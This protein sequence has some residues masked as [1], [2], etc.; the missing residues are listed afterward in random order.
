VAE[1]NLDM[2]SPDT[3]LL[4]LLMGLRVFDKYV[5]EN[6]R[7]PASL[8]E[9]EKAVVILSFTLKSSGVIENFKIIKSQGQEYSTRLSD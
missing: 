1:A 3:L 7:K 2:R 4:L 8:N 5:E 9:G 6:I